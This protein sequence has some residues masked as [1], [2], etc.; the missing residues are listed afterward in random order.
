MYGDFIV[1]MFRV[2]F[3]ELTRDYFFL[4]FA[5]GIRSICLKWQVYSLLWA[6]IKI[7]A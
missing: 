4:N 6:F 3:V 1:E 5:G 2:Y 7:H